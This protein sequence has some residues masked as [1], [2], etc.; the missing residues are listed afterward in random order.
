MVISVVSGKGGA[1]KTSLAVAIAE[2]FRAEFYDLDVDAPNAEHFLQPEI[3]QTRSVLQAVPVFAAERCNACGTCTRLCR[4]HAL[5]KILNSVYL[6]ESLCHSCGLCKLACPEQAISYQDIEIG[7]IRSGKS[8]LTGQ[9][10]HIGDLTIGSTR[11]TYLIETMTKG[12]NSSTLCVIDGPPGNSCAAVAAIKP[13]DL[14]ILIAEPTPFGMHDMA[15][16]EQILARLNKKYLIIANKAQDNALVS[17][18]F[19]ARPK[20]PALIVYLDERYH[21]AN[22]AGAIL[23]REFPALRQ[24]LAVTISPE[25][26]SL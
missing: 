21:R 26:N 16:T 4:F 2:T 7:R 9:R 5:Y 6:T 13:A 14:V 25:L 3:E 8:K 22:L 20:Q 18:M 23:S 1:G 15:Q 10:V 19:Q 12:L 17:R 11:E 24:Q